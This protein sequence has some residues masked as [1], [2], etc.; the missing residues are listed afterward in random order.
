LGR[1]RRSEPE[2]N[3]I[4]PAA[5]AL[6]ALGA[7]NWGLIGAANVDAI[8]MAFGR[9]AAVRAAYGVVGESAASRPRCKGGLMPPTRVGSSTPVG[10]PVLLEAAPLV[11]LLDAAHRR[12]GSRTTAR[13]L[14]RVHARHGSRVDAICTDLAAS[15]V[16][17]REA[18]TWKGP[19]GR[20]FVQPSRCGQTSAAKSVHFRA[21]RPAN[22][23]WLP[24][25]RRPH[26]YPPRPVPA[27]RYRYPRALP[28]PTA[29]YRYPPPATVTR[30]PP[31]LL[32]TATGYRYSPP[33]SPPRDS[34]GTVSCRLPTHP[35]TSLEPSVTNL[36]IARH[37][38]A[39]LV[40]PESRAFCRHP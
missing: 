4:D 13:S 7:L 34:L 3:A 40:A 2:V 29:H 12:H 10:G 8:R 32:A 36:R 39:V 35:A 9:S 22:R 30:R 14:D 24:D 18:C 6:L 28:V 26:R 16:A 25:I 15:A 5:G 33:A 1:N 19:P 17:R 11:H 31:P 37:V 21:G 38:D 20:I 23:R 27:A